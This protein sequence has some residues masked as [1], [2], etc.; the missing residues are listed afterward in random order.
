MWETP[1][2]GVIICV[3]L[4]MTWH[5][6]PEF[7][8]DRRKDTKLQLLWSKETHSPALVRTFSPGAGLCLSFLFLVGSWGCYLILRSDFIQVAMALPRLGSPVAIYLCL[9]G[10]GQTDF[11]LLFAFLNCWLLFHQ[12]AGGSTAR[13]HQP[14]GF[15]ESSVWAGAISIS[16]QGT[17]APMCPRA[18]FLLAYLVS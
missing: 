9:W 10:C 6:C 15:A 13:R 4:S 18:F 8:P 7:L 3:S 5:A 1:Y 2:C 17:F 16:E 14:E 11:T 12:C